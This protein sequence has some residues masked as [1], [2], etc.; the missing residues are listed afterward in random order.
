MIMQVFLSV[1]FFCIF[2]MLLSQNNQESVEIFYNCQND[3]VACYETIKGYTLII[4]TL[5]EPSANAFYHQEAGQS[6]QH[7]PNVQIY[8]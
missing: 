3:C 7:S 2:S 1:H 8:F 5:T 6:A 4:K